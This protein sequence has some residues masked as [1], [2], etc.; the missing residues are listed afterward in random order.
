M[1]YEPGAVPT[2]RGESFVVSNES[3]PS[4]RIH[5]DH[6]LL[7]RLSG[8]NSPDEWE[9]TLRRSG[10]WNLSPTT[11]DQGKLVRDLVRTVEAWPRASVAPMPTFVP[12]TARHWAVAVGLGAV[13]VSI[14]LA[15]FVAGLALTAALVLAASL[16]VV[17]V[18]AEGVRSQQRSAVAPEGKR[19]TQLLRALLGRTFVDVAGETIVENLPHRD[20]LELRMG[21]IDRALLGSEARIAEINQTLAGIRATNLRLGRNLDDPETANLA[22][23]LAVEHRMQQRIESVR[24][25]LREK[26]STFDAQLERMRVLAERRALSERVARLTDA[27]PGDEAVRA[28]ADIEVDVVGIEREI[29][30]LKLGVLEDDARLRSLLEVVGARRK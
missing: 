7:W 10:L 21:E 13:L 9:K 6:E 4:A 2:S 3:S 29:S 18:E 5:L 16:W 22:D 15:S 25:T 1:D 23:A 19:A 14:Y 20:Y 30:A 8:E 24:D 26:R 28:A 27:G 11:S 17:W 12:S